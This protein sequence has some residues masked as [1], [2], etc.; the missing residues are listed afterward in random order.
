MNKKQILDKIKRNLDQR[1]IS[2]V[3]NASDVT[4][5][6]IVISC[7]DA[8]IQ[9]PMGGIDGSSSPFL[10]MGVANPGKLVVTIADMTAVDFVTASALL[11]V[12]CEVFSFAN[13]VKVTDGTNT[14]V[15]SSLAD[16]VGLGQ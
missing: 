14:A 8:S 2:A 4:V 10:G 13:D 1:K 12:L 11:P 6:A 7:E 16:F 15:V 3:R 5:G 9:S